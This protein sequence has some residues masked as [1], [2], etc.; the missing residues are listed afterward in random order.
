MNKEI[1]MNIM[2]Y[3]DERYSGPLLSG[4]PLH[5]GGCEDGIYGCRKCSAAGRQLTDE[6]LIAIGWALTQT[7]SSCGSEVPLRDIH[8][9][10]AWGEPVYYEYCTKCCNAYWASIPSPDEW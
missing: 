10:K 6:Q 5:G 9:Y 7:C 2:P 4:K 1:T 8:G 3:P